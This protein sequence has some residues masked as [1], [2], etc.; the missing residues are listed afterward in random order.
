MLEMMDKIL[1]L[2][3]LDK[4]AGGSGRRYKIRGRKRRRIRN[5]NRRY[6]KRNLYPRITIAMR[7]IVNQCIMDSFKLSDMP[8]IISKISHLQHRHREKAH[9]F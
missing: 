7:V 9:Y 1:N 6:K 2:D 8:L 5:R 4:V 3:D